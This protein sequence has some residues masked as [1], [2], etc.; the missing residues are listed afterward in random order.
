[1][2][3][4]R[5]NRVFDAGRGFSLVELLAVIAILGILAALLI[6][7]VGA[8]Q[9]RARQSQSQALFSQLATACL[10]Y[11]SDYGH[12]PL[13]GQPRGPGDT[14]I[15]F[16]VAGGNIYRTLTGFDPQTG[17][18]ILQTPHAGLNR[19]GRSYYSFAEG[20][21]EGEHVVDSFGNRDIIL[22][23]DTDGN[24]QL[25]HTF[26]NGLEPAAHVDGNPRDAFKPDF[27]VN[28]RQPVI[29][30]SAGAGAGREVRT[31]TRRDE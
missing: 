28:L 10:N 22:V 29:L 2:K 11:R 8:I 17:Q 13:F 27:T 7:V 26:L 19:R 3:L 25:S 24:G 16:S 4:A 21:L 14:A 18:S 5:K 31:W 30:Y 9:V 1:M 12:F 15:R 23:L 6:P 20:D